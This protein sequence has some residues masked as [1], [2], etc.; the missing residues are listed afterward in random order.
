MAIMRSRG[1]AGWKFSKAMIANDTNCHL[2][3]QYVA[4]ATIT[5]SA[6]KVQIYISRPRNKCSSKRSK[7]PN[8]DGVNNYSLELK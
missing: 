2:R 8:N 4:D 6:V 7:H 5:H 1:S 3:Q